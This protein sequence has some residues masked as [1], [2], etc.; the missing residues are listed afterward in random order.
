YA[1]THVELRRLNSALIT[2]QL[3]RINDAEKLGLGAKDI[4]T[5]VKNCADDIRAAINDLQSKNTESARDR[6]K[7]IY[8]A[9]RAVFHSKYADARAAV[10]A[11]GEEHDDIKSWIG[12]NMPFEFQ[13]GNGSS[14]G[15][16]AIALGRGFDMLS[17]ADMFDGRI[18]KRQY[19]VLLKYS[20]DLLSGGVAVARQGAAS[21]YVKYEKPPFNY[22]FSKTFGTAKKAAK[23]IATAAHC[24]T[25]DAPWFFPIISAQFKAHPN[26]VR[27]FWGFETEELA[28]VCKS[29]E[30]AVKDALEKD[31]E[32]YE[33]REKE[34]EE[35]ERGSEPAGAKRGGLIDS[36]FEKNAEKKKEPEDGKPENENKIADS[37]KS[38]P[39]AKHKAHEKKAGA[40][41]ESETSKTKE[42]DA[43][44]VK[45]TASLADFM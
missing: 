9:A 37:K 12:W 4:D 35:I 15:A 20:S 33:K 26:L 27:D 11:C 8:D 43:K 3:E 23:K 22:K 13:D 36:T 18:M 42:P 19:W 45:K 6:E 39:E 32:P 21:R 30:S 1:C 38:V 28:F 17:R 2:K 7:S 44:P 41:K 5:I 34:R 31:R 40:K 24:P 10:F 14:S 25:R 16:H 29:N